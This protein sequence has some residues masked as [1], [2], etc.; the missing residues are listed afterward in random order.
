MLAAFEAAAAEWPP[1]H[2]HVEY[3]TPKLAAAQS[4]GFVVALAR[5][6]MELTIPPGKS[7]LQAILD[8]GIEAPHS[9]EEGVCGACETRVISGIPDHRD[10]ILT[11]QERQENA[12]MMIC[13]GGSK[14][15]RLVLDM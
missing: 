5:S 8:A 2:V 14:S 10:S 9:C 7:I 13:C 6:K 15:P 11:E 4:G 12:T 3:F 1:E